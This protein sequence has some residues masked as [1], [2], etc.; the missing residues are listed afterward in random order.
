MRS[1]NLQLVSGELKHEVFRK[2]VVLT[3][4][5]FIQ[6]RGVNPVELGKVGI[7]HDPRATEKID[8]PAVESGRDK[9]VW[10]GLRHFQILEVPNRN[11]KTPNPII[12]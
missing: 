9:L 12:E 7:E 5:C 4:D 6:T 11:I 2:S 8:F 3:Q 1:Q 10:D